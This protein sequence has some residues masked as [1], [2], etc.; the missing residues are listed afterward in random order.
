VTQFITKMPNFLSVLTG[1]R[2]LPRRLYKKTAKSTSYLSLSGEVLYGA[3]PVQMALS[4]NRRTVHCL[5]YNPGSYRTEQVVQTCQDRGV[6][7]RQVDRQGLTDICRQADRYKE[8]HVHQGMVADVSKLYHYPIDYTM[9]Q[10][11]QSPPVT[12][13]RPANSPPPVW[14]LLCSVKDPYN[15]G[16]I[17]RT[18]YYLGVERVIVTGTR[19]DL[20]CTV[21]KASAGTLEVTPVFAVRNAPNLLESKVEEGWRVLAAAMPEDNQDSSSMP[22]ESSVCPSMPVD[23]ISLTCPTILVLGSEGAGI[24]PEVMSCVTQGVYISPS[25]WVDTQV[26]SLNVSVAAAIVIHKLCSSAGVGS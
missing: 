19:C 7:C 9:P 1:H 12:H 16:T 11:T 6:L 5:Y 15:L 24:P 17:I 21:S 18:A 4:A 26:D 13:T 2:L 14:L 10:V 20:S 25:K 3:Q 22:L 8:H 23:S